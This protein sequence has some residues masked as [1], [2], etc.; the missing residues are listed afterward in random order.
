MH[1]HNTD[2]Q[3]HKGFVWDLNLDSQYLHKKPSVVVYACHPSSEEHKKLHLEH[4]GGWLGIQSSWN[5]EFQ[6][7]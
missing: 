6:G 1:T 4:L 3:N 5:D 2:F 7:L